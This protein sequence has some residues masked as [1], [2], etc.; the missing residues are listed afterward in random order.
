MAICKTCGS[1][2]QPG[3]SFC[4]VCGQGLFAAEDAL[5]CSACNTPNAPGTRFCKHCGAVLLRKPKAV[6]GPVCG[7]E[8]AEDALYC[9]ACGS[10]MP[11]EFEKEFEVENIE[12]LQAV[13]PLLHSFADSYNAEFDRLSPEE[14]EKTTYVCPV[15][16][17]RND[18]GDVKCRRCGRDRNRSEYLAS[19][20]RIT[21]FEDAVEIPDGLHTPSQPAPAFPVTTDKKPE[22]LNGKRSADSTPVGRAENVSAGYAGGYAGYARDGFVQ[23]SPIVQP[24]AIVPY[25]TQ[26]Q[27]L[28]QYASKSDYE[29]LRARNSNGKK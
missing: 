4:P 5:I 18:L 27:P 21:S 23:S 1:V 24:L 17:K 12:K 19:K 28:W 25:V 8:N 16:G 26:E 9:T 7:S 10:E 6:Q 13:L 11:G 14:L 20:Q 2:V 15:C 22:F 3:D 29:K